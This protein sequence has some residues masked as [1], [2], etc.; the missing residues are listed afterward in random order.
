MQSNFLESDSLSGKRIV[1][2]GI[3]RLQSFPTVNH[4]KQIDALYNE[5]QASGIDEVYCISFENFVLFNHLA[6]KF[7][8]TVKFVQLSTDADV[9]AF[10]KLLGKKGNPDFLRQ[11]WQFA[12]ILNDNNVQYYIEQSF[13]RIKIGPDTKEKIYSDVGPEVVLATLRGV[14]SVG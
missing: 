12:C 11:Y 9:Q 10:Q 7:S 2:F 13:K 5:F 1:I 4:I 14:S 8:K 3:N 6:P